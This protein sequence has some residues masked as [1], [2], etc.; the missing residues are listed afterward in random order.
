MS[1]LEYFHHLYPKSS[2]NSLNILGSRCNDGGDEGRSL[3]QVGKLKD[4]IDL[5]LSAVNQ[6]VSQME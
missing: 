2:D 3:S 6:A 5:L 4:K 1:I